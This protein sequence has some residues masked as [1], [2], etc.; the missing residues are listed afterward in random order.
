L[1]IDLDGT[2]YGQIS[3]R[4]PTESLDHDAIMSAVVSGTLA[5]LGTVSPLAAG[6]R[7]LFGGE[8]LNSERSSRANDVQP[9]EVDALAKFQKIF[10]NLVGAKAGNDPVYVFIDDLDRAQPDVA[11]DIL[12]SIRIALYESECIYILAVDDRLIAQGMRLRYRELFERVDGLEAASTGREYLEKIIQFRTRV[13]APT[14]EQTQRLIA[15]DFSHWASAGDIIQS[16]IGN[17]PRRVKQ[18][19][20]RLIFQ[21]VVGNP[22]TVGAAPAEEMVYGGLGVRDQELNVSE[23]NNLPAENKLA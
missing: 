4:T 23:V 1:K 5:V 21:N 14:P 8:P 13:P 18:Y 19:C 20:H 15:A 22:F 9:T 11:F 10:R 3:R 12:E 6:I 2:D 17:N 7:S 16:V